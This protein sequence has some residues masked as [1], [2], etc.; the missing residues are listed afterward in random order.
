MTNKRNRK[1]FPL[2]A[3]ALLLLAIGGGVAYIALGFR[4]SGG[5]G[6]MDEARRL[7]PLVEA[8]PPPTATDRKTEALGIVYPNGEWVVG[9]AKD[10]HA[11]YS[12]LT[13]GGTV[14]L[15]DSRGRVRCFFGHVCG[16]GNIGYASNVDSLDAFDAHLAKQFVEQAWP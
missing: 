15:K 7:R 5:M 12:R 4:Y 10:S 16:D 1:W 13:G 6:S 8:M 9:V 3:A 11:L 2:I 14:V